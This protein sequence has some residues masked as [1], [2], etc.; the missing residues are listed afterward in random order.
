L[1]YRR[2]YRKNCIQ[3]FKPLDHSRHPDQ[4]TNFI[5]FRGSFITVQIC[6]TFS[7]SLI[8]TRFSAEFDAQPKLQRRDSAAGFAAYI[9][10]S[11]MGTFVNRA[12]AEYSFTRGSDVVRD[13]MFLEAEVI[14][15]SKHRTVA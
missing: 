8:T 5:A 10:L 11:L 1:G 12:G 15:A 13:G 6:S 7:H 14:G 2:E 4:R 3:Q 9:K